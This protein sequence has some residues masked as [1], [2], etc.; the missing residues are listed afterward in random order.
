MK[1]FAAILFAIIIL[2]WLFLFV[3][4]SQSERSIFPNSD[5]NIYA[6]TD[7]IIGGFSTSHLTLSES[8]LVANVN[9][10]SGVAYAFAGAGF[11][12]R[13]VRNRPVAHFDFSKFDSVKIKVET[14][15]MK[16]IGLKILTDD[17]IYTKDNYIQSFRPLIISVPIKKDEVTASLFDLKVP[18]YWL[19]SMGLDSDDGM[20]YMQRGVEFQVYNGD[21]TMRGIP[22][23]ITIKSITFVGENCTF[24]VMMFIALSVI[25][26]VYISLIFVAIKNSKKFVAL[27][28]NKAENLKRKMALAA[29]ILNESDRSLTEIAKIVGEKNSTTLETNFKK[30]YGVTPTDY[31]K[32]K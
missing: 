4:F 8:L 31:R 32:C 13:S 27:Q 6:L 19:V 3:K 15:R 29:K 21:A 22:D 23:E 18:D 26:L 12:L 9:I 11:N 1:K 28:K 17:P 10:R 5:Y 30:I 2:L 7:S 16:N 20:R 25:L 14:N 24:K